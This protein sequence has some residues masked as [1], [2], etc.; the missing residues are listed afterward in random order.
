[1]LS[2][3]AALNEMT[4][5]SLL[6]GQT[7]LPTSPESSSPFW[8]ST[9]QAVHLSFHESLLYITLRRVPSQQARSY[10]NQV[11]SRSKC[12]FQQTV[13]H[14]LDHLYKKVLSQT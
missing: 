7:L 10:L 14:N 9:T 2:L 13:R 6:P 12:Q 11:Y 1:M 8:N 5:Y 4:G 3:L